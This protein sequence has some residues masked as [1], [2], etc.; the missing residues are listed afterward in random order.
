MFTKKLVFDG[1]VLQ[2]NDDKL[3]NN[4]EMLQYFNNHVSDMS[5]AKQIEALL[6]GIKKM[7]RDNKYND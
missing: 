3:L 4:L 6:R 7:S 2:V 5:S 1:K